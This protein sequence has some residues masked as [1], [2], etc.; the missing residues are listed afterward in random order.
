MRVGLGIQLKLRYRMIVKVHKTQ[1]GRKIVA[2]CDNDLIG[3]KF[4][5][6][7]LQ[8]DLSSSFYQ[9]EEMS[10]KGV[11]E[12]VKGCYVVN[13]VGEKSIKLA[14]KWGIVDKGNIIKI[15]NIPQVQA[16]LG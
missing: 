3:K 13:I 16:I 2:I 6:G 10:E 7:N 8:L 12:S 9:G 11:M 14:I 5:E 15:K 1:D 4:G